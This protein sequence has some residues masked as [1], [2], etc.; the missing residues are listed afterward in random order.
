MVCARLN[1]KAAILSG[2]E[3]RLKNES[4]VELQTGIEE[5]KKITLL[6]LQNIVQE[7]LDKSSL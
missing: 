6:R 2:I 7:D 5:V 3:E 4:D 1:K